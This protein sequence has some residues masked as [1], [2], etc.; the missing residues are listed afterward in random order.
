MRTAQMFTR[1]I[2]AGLIMIGSVSLAFPQSG[3]GG[4]EGT[5]LGPTE[6]VIPAAAVKV[7]H[8][9]T[10]VA[11]ET[12]TNAAG[13]YLAPALNPGNYTILVSALGMQNWSG[14]ALL[15]V[16]QALRIDVRMQ[17]GRPTR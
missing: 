12:K 10:G 3:Q 5:V 8:E 7:V 14:K 9:A 17:V 6:A 11:L 15:E 1:F 16:G 13:F 2:C 4:I